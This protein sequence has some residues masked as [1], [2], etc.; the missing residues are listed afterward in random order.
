MRSLAL[1]LVVAAALLLVLRFYPSSPVEGAGG[2]PA[3]A[4]PAAGFEDQ[5]LADALSTGPA[6]ATAPA[7]P[8]PSS[9]A[10]ASPPSARDALP[11][12][13]PVASAPAPSSA[14]TV[15]AGALLHA[16]PGE[17][18]ETLAAQKIA[19][20]RRTC[21]E[22]FAA[23]IA[24]DRERANALAAGLAAGADLPAE[25]RQALD[26]AL[27]E[28][29]AVPRAAPARTD[30]PVVLAM[31]MALLAQEARGLLAAGAS[32]A[33]ARDF[34]E[35]LLLEIEAPWPSDR[36]VLA[37]WSEGL[38]AAQ[39]NHRWNP[40][41]DWPAV[42]I[43]VEEGDHLTAIRKR[44]LAEHP[45]RLVCTGLIARANRIAGPIH[46][47][48]ELRIPTEPVHVIVDLGARW[49]LYLHG[50]EVV[51]AWE[52]GI[53]RPGEETVT[54]NFVV[55]EKNEDPTWFKLG[56]DPVPF[57]DPRNPLGSRW[58]GW[59]QGGRPTSYGFHG[60]RDPESIGQAASD[61]CIR[62]LDRDVEELFEIL[63]VGAA[64]R[65]Q[66]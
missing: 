61:G 29:G 36:A 16:R 58:I 26:L 37:A 23:A 33:A 52:V 41:G 2:D 49:V 54:G 50:T 35:L 56:Q 40:R 63:P 25:E 14:E 32:A 64:I 27:G 9:P 65:V 39:R 18:A 45:D 34:S 28:A 31:R 3:G 4:A 55:G 44:Y 21:L 53:G 13:P 12:E 51:G 66:G 47:G 10:L 46:P 60:T 11:P 17:L 1:L 57:G 8:A 48:D 62:L 15:L 42:E 7:S 5:F 30:G 22:A 19:G 6:S 24:G 38:A 43:T 59:N 20:A